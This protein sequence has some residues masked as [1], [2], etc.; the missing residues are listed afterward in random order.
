MEFSKQEY[1]SGLPLPTS[2]DLPNLGIE[3]GSPALQTESL[4]SESPEK[5]DQMG[6]KNAHTPAMRD[7]LSF[8][9]RLDPIL[10]SLVPGCEGGGE[11]NESTKLGLRS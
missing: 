11:M 5:A 4:P 6:I 1:C 7:M 10:R 2:E 3:P 8:W 9:G